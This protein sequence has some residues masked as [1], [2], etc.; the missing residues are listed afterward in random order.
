FVAI[1]PV[2]A[3][4]CRSK[5]QTFSLS[6]SVETSK[7]G[8]ER[9]NN[10]DIF[11]YKGSIKDKI[12]SMAK[13]L[14]P[15]GPSG[16]NLAGEDVG[17]GVFEAIKGPNGELQNINWPP[18]PWAYL[19]NAAG[20]INTSTFYFGMELDFFDIV[21]VASV[22]S[23][24][25]MHAV[26]KEL[27]LVKR[28]DDKNDAN[29]Q[30]FRRNENGELVLNVVP[31]MTFNGM[32]IYQVASET[33][34]RMLNSFK[35]A[36]TGV[37]D[38]VTLESI[39]AISRFS[40]FFPIREG[41]TVMSLKNMCQEVYASRVRKIAEDDL[42][43]FLLASIQSDD[44]QD[45]LKLIINAALYGGELKRVPH[46][47]HHWNI[48]KASITANKNIVTVR[49]EIDQ[50]VKGLRDNRMNYTCEFVDDQK[51]KDEKPI[52]KGNLQRGWENT[53]RDIVDKICHDANLEFRGRSGSF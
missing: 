20:M 37:T 28:P 30:L 22:G 29:N 11:Y 48:K 19:T 6:S 24:A 25:F 15:R 40:S 27:L 16:L 32:C 51:T 31:G 2:M 8:D 49:G 26:D 9:I 46:G 52:K 43:N 13:N 47:G 53:A 18:A 34:Y 10:L 39:T 50:N 33:S 1:I 14:Q 4:G 45:N 5:E 23:I 35:L 36:G 38:M 44:R 12:D 17:P 3:A 41:D 21:S 42:N 7:A